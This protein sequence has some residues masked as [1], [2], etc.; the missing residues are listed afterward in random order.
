MIK[1]PIE[2]NTTIEEFLKFANKNRLSKEF[3]NKIKNSKGFKDGMKMLESDFMHL[4]MPDQRLVS[5]DVKKKN[6]REKNKEVDVND[7]SKD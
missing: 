2:L 3:M 1:L 5:N 4:E 6:K 7:E